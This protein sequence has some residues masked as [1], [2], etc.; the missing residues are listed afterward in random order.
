MDSDALAERLLGFAVDIIKISSNIPNT[1]TAQHIYQQLIESASSCG[2]EF[3]ENLVNKPETGSGQKLQS[4]LK[5][6]RKT[7][8]WLKLLRQSGLVESNKIEPLIQESCELIK[9]I[10]KSVKSAKS[11]RIR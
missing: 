10:S 7:N 8:Y 9:I 3:E 2:A 6:M 4:V 1:Y 11:E 5:E